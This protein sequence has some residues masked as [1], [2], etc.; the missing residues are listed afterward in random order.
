MAFPREGPLAAYR[1]A[2]SR[3]PILDGGGA[4]LHDAR[5]HSKGRRII[6]C[7]ST[8]AAAQLEQLVHGNLSELPV[9]HAYVEISIPHGVSISELAADDLPAN[10]IDDVESTRR[11]GNNWYDEMRSAVLCVPSVVTHGVEYNLLINQV[12]SDFLMIQFT[13][14]RKVQYDPRFSR[15]GTDTFS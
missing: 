8:Y 11:L 5:W 10:W 1:I 13:E 12:H 7:A 6:Y 2:S 14:P 3:Y 4:F 9:N 15:R